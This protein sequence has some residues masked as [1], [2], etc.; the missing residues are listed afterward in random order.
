VKKLL[1]AAAIGL[2]L[3]APA[4]EAGTI[5]VF[6][7]NGTADTVTGT[8]TTTNCNSLA[9]CFTTVSVQN[10]AITITA[11]QNG[12]PP[13]SAF[14]D[15]TAVSFDS[16]SGIL[17]INQDFAGH[18]CI[19]S[20]IN[21]TGTNY[22]SGIFTDLVAGLLGSAGLTMSSGNP[23]ENVTFTS[24]VI[25]DLGTPLGLSFGFTNVFPGVGLCGTGADRTICD[26]TSNVAGNFSGSTPNQTPEP[27]PLALAGLGLVAL[28]WA[29]RRQHR[30]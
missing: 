29:R 7:Q 13:I 27:T 25:T 14:L 21:C 20:G 19:T 3:A 28:G 30:Q 2:A 4:A 12:A 16:A 6:G 26:F 24:D 23:P 1:L 5:L 8:A 15:L 17:G 22:L 11:I 10:A 18:F 9:T